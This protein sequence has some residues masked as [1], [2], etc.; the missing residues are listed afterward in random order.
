MSRPNTVRDWQE[1]L[2]KGG[3][4]DAGRRVFFSA[5]S[6]CSAC[7]VVN[8]RGI[9]LGS[10]SA[11]GFIAMP[12]GPDL[13]VIGRTA[14][15]NALIHSIVRP[16]DYIAPEYQ[17]WFVKMKDGKMNTGREIDQERNAIQLIML[18]GYEHNFPRK[19]VESWGAMEH[20]LMP[21]GFPQTMA[22][23]EFRDLIEFLH[24]LK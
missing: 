11:A 16:S 17:G 7:H 19:D 8:G 21:E 18:D 5:N 4:P 24:S 14:N 3:D 13:S 15:R 9:K 6:A 22:V 12:I 23:E 20:S 1:L 2:R 10:G